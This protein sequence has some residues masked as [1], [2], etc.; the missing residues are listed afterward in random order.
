MAKH[1]G[2]RYLYQEQ[3]S[4]SRPAHV[5]VEPLNLADLLAAMPHQ[6]IVKLH[7]SALDADAELVSQ[8]LA[9]IPE[10]DALVRQTCK[11]WVKKFQFEK[12]L[13]LTEP[14]VGR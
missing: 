5:T 9:E 10:S 8:I 12:I 11:G 2:V 7:E 13:D 3:E 6:W 1:L 4:P 14:L